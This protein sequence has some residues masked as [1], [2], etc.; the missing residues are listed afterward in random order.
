[1]ITLQEKELLRREM[2]EE[3]KLEE[4]QHIDRCNEDYDYLMESYGVIELHEKLESII[5]K[6]NADGYIID[7]SQVLEYLNEL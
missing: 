2:M 4:L 1:M 5:N 7:R 6:L 3:Q